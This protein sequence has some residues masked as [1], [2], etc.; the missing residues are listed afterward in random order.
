MATSPKSPFRKRLEKKH[1]YLFVEH[2]K[3]GER[4]F[5]WIAE[6]EQLSVELSDVSSTTG[7]SVASRN[8]D[9]DK[10]N[11]LTLWD[12]QD[13]RD[14]D[15]VDRVSNEV[16]GLY[17][18]FRS[19]IFNHSFEAPEAEQSILIST[20]FTT[21]DHSIGFIKDGDDGD[22]Q[23]NIN[24][25]R[26][27]LHSST[28]LRPGYIW[29]VDED[30]S[31]WGSSEPVG[32]VCINVYMPFAQALRLQAQLKQLIGDG[33]SRRIR[34]RLSVLAFQSEVER[35][36]AEPYHSQTPLATARSAQ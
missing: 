8:F 24:T 23:Q 35:S 3:E 16:A 5:N 14:A 11:C 32:T 18:K 27:M 19:M 29:I 30:E 21:E 34:A 1:A 10:G 36:L 4:P 22:R 20:T 7:E 9:V 15:V 6:W 17:A 28:G 25:G 13:S 31:K 26:L 2:W 33:L 12:E